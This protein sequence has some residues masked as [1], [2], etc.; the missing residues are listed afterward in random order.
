LVEEK[1]GRFLARKEVKFLVFMII[2]R[3]GVALGFLNN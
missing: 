3:C 1:K 2:R